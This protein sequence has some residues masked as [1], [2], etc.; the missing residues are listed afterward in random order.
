ML[1]DPQQRAFDT[2]NGIIPARS[3]LGLR[4]DPDLAV[5]EVELLL[6]PRIGYSEVP[7]GAELALHQESSPT[8]WCRRE[9][10]DTSS[11]RTVSWQR[12]DTDQPEH[13]QLRRGFCFPEIPYLKGIF[14]SYLGESKPGPTHYKKVP[15]VLADDGEAWFRLPCQ[16]V[17]LE[18]APEPF[19]K[20]LS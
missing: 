16:Q 19:R 18:E 13:D 3:D 7:T 5:H 14:S 4:L 15:A 1:R 10:H 12:S 2:I 11:F 9:C 8:S 6:S 17:S 20:L